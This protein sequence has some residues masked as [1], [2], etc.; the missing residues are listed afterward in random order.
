[1]FAGL[2]WKTYYALRKE[3]CGTPE[4]DAIL[5]LSC[6]IQD[7]I[8]LLSFASFLYDIAVLLLSFQKKNNF[9]IIFPPINI[10]HV[11]FTC[12]ACVLLLL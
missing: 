8:M 9:L 6:G 7:N 5:V 12:H 2:S 10:S 3:V 4:L 11:S 1:M